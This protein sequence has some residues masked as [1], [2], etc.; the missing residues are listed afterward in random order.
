MARCHETVAVTARNRLPIPHPPIVQ[1]SQTD[2]VSFW[3]S[4]VGPCL[5]EV[6][7]GELVVFQVLWASQ[8]LWQVMRICSC[9]GRPFDSCFR[10]SQ[11]GLSY[12]MV[13]RLHPYV[14]ELIG[15]I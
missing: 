11:V 13:G 2:L 7:K 15:T 9:S 8:D 12:V 6:P 3:C 10:A 5:V 4:H 14:D 1:L